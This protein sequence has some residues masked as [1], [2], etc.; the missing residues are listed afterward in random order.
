MRPLAHVL[1][2]T[3]VTAGVQVSQADQK[4]SQTHTATYLA[5]SH[6][7][8]DSRHGGF[9]ALVLAVPRA[10]STQAVTGFVMTGY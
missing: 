1:M 10:V 6:S 8:L 9:K 5:K 7:G 3:A 2:G 4:E